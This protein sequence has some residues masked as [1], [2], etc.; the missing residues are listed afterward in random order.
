MK[1]GE[2]VAA[3]V[4]GI[5]AFIVT[6]AFEWSQLA[7]LVLGGSVGVVMFL[8]VS[9]MFK[10]EALQMLWSIRHSILSKT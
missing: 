1:H 8:F 10:V 2:K 4:A 6:Q 5:A 9:V 7:L 3:A